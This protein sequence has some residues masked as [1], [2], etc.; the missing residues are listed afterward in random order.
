M[1]QLPKYNTFSIFFTKIQHGKIYVSV[2]MSNDH[3]ETLFF[4]TEKVSHKK[5]INSFITVHFGTIY[6][7]IYIYI[8][9]L[10]LTSVS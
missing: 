6:I 4:L 8:Y 1:G 7:Y 3:N 9:T 2:L 5:I 10:V